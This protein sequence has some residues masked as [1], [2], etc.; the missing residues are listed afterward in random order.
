M[1]FNSDPNKHAVEVSFSKKKNP[2]NSNLYSFNDAPIKNVPEQR[3]LGTILDSKLSFSSHIK[4][5][6]SKSRQGIGILRFLT[7]YLPRHTLN[8]IYKLYVWPHL[9]H[10][11]IVFHITH[12]ICEFSHDHKLTNPM[13]KLEAVQYSA[14]LSVTGA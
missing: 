11:D 7:K 3:H 10:G 9:D 1:S 14:E 6:N 8:E 5:I 13:E 12:K 2:M 4:S